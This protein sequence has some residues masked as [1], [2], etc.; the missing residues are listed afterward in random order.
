LQLHNLTPR[1]AETLV[2]RRL[3]EFLAPFA[4]LPDLAG[5][6]ERDG[7][8]P[9]GRAWSSQHL[10]TR[11]DI[12]SRDVI[13][14][15][16]DGWQA[17]Q[18]RLARL[19]KQAW[20]RGWPGEGDR[21]LA[22]PPPVWNQEQ[23]QSAIDQAVTA[24][25]ETL[26]RRFHAD[27]VSL[28]AE[29][30]RLAG[31]LFD[32]LQQ[33]REAGAAPGLIEVRR[34]PPPRPGAQPTYHLSLKRRDEREE[35]SGV[36]VMATE[37]KQAVAGF[38]RRLC[39]DSRPLDRV[40]IVTDERTGMPLGDKGKEYLED[41]QSRGPDRF[42]VIVLPFAERANLEALAGVVGRARSGDVEIE[43]PGGG[44]RVLTPAEVVASHHRQGRYAGN[45]LLAG[46]LRP[47]EPLVTAVPAD[48]GA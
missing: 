39:E 41:L 25:M 2:R 31:V 3:D 12:R 28:P 17:Q 19:S 32:L 30:D 37:A 34:L 21:E 22:P 4:R 27:P 14:L 43:L 5:P 35:I 42:A 40:V 18:E 16:R 23:E 20:L 7:L 1:Q 33:C 24:E 29:A 11:S 46:L 15:A 13:S 45:R 47:A 38:L 8:F 26:R 9:L 6:R 48:S 36:L 10:L 44:C